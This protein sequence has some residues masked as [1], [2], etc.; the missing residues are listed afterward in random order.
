MRARTLS[1]SCFA[2]IHHIASFIGIAWPEAAIHRMACFGPNGT[3]RPCTRTHCRFS[4][5][6][7]P[8]PG[9]ALTIC[10]LGP[11]RDDQSEC[12]PEGTKLRNVQSPAR[13]RVKKARSNKVNWQTCEM[14]SANVGKWRMAAV[15]CRSLALISLSAICPHNSH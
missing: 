8:W 7:P 6:S 12:E 1:Y 4:S 2:S 3:P 13:A 9:L 14:Q 11:Q 10:L 15:R 5:A